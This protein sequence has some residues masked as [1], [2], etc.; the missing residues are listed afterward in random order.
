MICTTAS[1][2]AAVSGVLKCSN[3]R[4]S[5]VARQS[6][7]RSGVTVSSRSV[8]ITPRGRSLSVSVVAIQGI[9][10]NYEEEDKVVT[11]KMSKWGAY[12]DNQ[13]PSESWIED[14]SK[15]FPEDGVA[16]V[17][18]ART[19]IGDELGYKYLDI[20]AEFE[21]NLGKVTGCVHIPLINARYM[22]NEKSERVL[23]QTVNKDFLKQVQ[24]KFPS[25]DSKIVI[26]C[27]DGTNRAIQALIQL[28]KL[29]YT[30]IVGVR[31]GD[32]GGINKFDSKFNRRRSDGY[33]EKYDGNGS[34][35][36]GIHASGAGFA[37]MDAMDRIRIKD[38]TQWID[39]E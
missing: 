15:R 5:S 28:D 6:A 20:R 27:S 32:N 30:N 25:K 2:L 12:M 24:A 14:V 4:K 13:Y 22:Y 29:G 23:M 16:T 8:S 26:G 10:Y 31:G 39:W 33:T 21:L 37:R 1:S 19:L 9:S 35:S 18:E 7:F 17:E 38:D 34:D 3:P 11:A 36:A